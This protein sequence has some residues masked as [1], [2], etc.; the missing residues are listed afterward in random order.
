MPAGEVQGTR[1]HKGPGGLHDHWFLVI[2]HGKNYLTFVAVTEEF[3]IIDLENQR[4]GEPLI[5][6]ELHGA[7]R[8]HLQPQDCRE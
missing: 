5:V 3:A 4:D 2:D 6:V 1:R 7:C 8:S